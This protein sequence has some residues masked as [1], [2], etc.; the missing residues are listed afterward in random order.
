[1]I[2]LSMRLLLGL[3]AALSIAACTTLPADPGLS[4]GSAMND[5][6]TKASQALVVSWRAFDALLTAVDALQ[7]GGILESGSPRAAKLAALIERARSALAAATDALRAGNGS[8]FTHSLNLAHSA[9][10]EA[11]AAIGGA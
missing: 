11:R 7:A 2:S 5:A 10:T 3:A 1:M 6:H 8:G 9:L 4:A